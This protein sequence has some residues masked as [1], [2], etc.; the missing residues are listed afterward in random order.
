MENQAGETN[1]S[2][3]SKQLGR[4]STENLMADEAANNVPPLPENVVE[5]II[6]KICNCNILNSRLVC[7]EWK[8]LVARRSLW[9]LRYKNQGVNWNAIESFIRGRDS[10]NNWVILHAQ[11]SHEILSKNYILNP[12]GHDG[13]LGW[14]TLMKH[15]FVEEI[16]RRCNPLPD[17]PLLG[18]V[19]TGCFVASTLWSSKS[20]QVDLWEEGVTPIVANLLPP[21]QVKCSQ[22]VA[23]RSDRSAVYSWKVQL[24]NSRETVYRQYAP[25]K[26]KIPASG[27]WTKVEYA[28]K[29]GRDAESIAD[30]KDLRYILFIHEGK[31]RYDDDVES[32]GPYGV[33]FAHVCVTLEGLHDEPSLE[34]MDSDRPKPP[35]LIREA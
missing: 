11:L 23:S 32:D 17:S 6:S 21:F 28:F 33:K 19:D 3:H 26:V 18:R 5:M 15:F 13:F 29:F 22:L 1:Q 30:L 9:K 24:L 34:S 16:P 27:Q 31:G 35:V 25:S 10:A 2:L 8:D 4:K 14:T 12:S 7:K 20:Y